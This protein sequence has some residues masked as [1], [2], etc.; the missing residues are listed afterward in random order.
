VRPRS[1]RAVDV[2]KQRAARHERSPRAGVD[3]HPTHARE[4]DDDAVVDGREPGDRVP[5][6]AHRDVEVL[7]AGELERAHD[8]RDARA[9]DD[10]GGTAVEGAVPDRASVVVAGVGG[11][12]HLAAQRLAELLHGGI[13]EGVGGCCCHWGDSSLGCWSI[14]TLR[15]G[16]FALA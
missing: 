10:E 5:A 9:P 7:G 15:G 12:D 11:G 6:A 1:A 8:V 14:A 2:A 13:A 16:L 3:G 4:V